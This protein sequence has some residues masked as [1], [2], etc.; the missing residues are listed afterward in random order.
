MLFP[1]P[2]MLFSLPDAYAM[3]WII[4]IMEAVSWI[5]PIF[6]ICMT[7]RVSRTFHWA[8]KHWKSDALGNSLTLYLMNMR[9]LRH[10]IIWVSAQAKPHFLG[11]AFPFLSKLDYF[12]VYS[13]ASH[14]H[15]LLLIVIADSLIISPTFS[16]SSSV[17]PALLKT[18]YPAFPS[19]C[20]KP[21]CPLRTQTEL[22]KVA[23]P[24]LHHRTSD[25]YDYFSIMQK[26]ILWHFL[27]YGYTIL[28]W[29]HG[30]FTT[31]TE[32]FDT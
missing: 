7:Y 21:D 6:L 24:V 17:T 16:H 4:G 18:Y 22:L 32:D 1:L 23:S 27:C 28:H 2:G 5:P 30:H 15:F 20:L 9:Y 11:E 14:L 3:V 25:H 12:L 26:A 8:R 19:S 29:F 13:F 10:H 31:L